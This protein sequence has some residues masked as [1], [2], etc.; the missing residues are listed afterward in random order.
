[1][2]TPNQKR[3]LSC[4]NVSKKKGCFKSRISSWKND[5]TLN[6]NVENYY[7]HKDIIG[8]NFMKRTEAVMNIGS[9]FI[10][11][12][13]RDRIP[14]VRTMIPERVDPWRNPQTNLIKAK[15]L[16]TTVIPPKTSVISPALLSQSSPD[17]TTLY[18]Q[19]WDDQQFIVIAPTVTEYKRQ[20]PLT[21]HNP[22]KKTVRI[23]F[24]TVVAYFD[25][26]T[27]ING[28]ISASTM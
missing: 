25:A 22:T 14:M 18:L 1:M 9:D 8:R 12:F 13:E 16:M 11:M 21:L 7:D 4:P 24:E 10:T 19:Q 23:P 17:G 2:I 28:M 5:P 20:M 3:S 27:D 26:I 15:L 6:F